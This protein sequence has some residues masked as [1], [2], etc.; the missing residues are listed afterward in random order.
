MSIFNRMIE[1]IELKKK[2]EDY[3]NSHVYWEIFKIKIR[4][5]QAEYACE[6]LKKA[7]Y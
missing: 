5:M 3:F 6:D 7:G 4:E 2:S 1:W